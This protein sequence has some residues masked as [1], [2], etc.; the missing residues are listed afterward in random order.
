MARPF[1]KWVGGKTQLLDELEK[2]LPPCSDEG[3]DYVEPFLGG[4]ALFFHLQKNG[5][6]KSA[7]LNDANAELILCYRAVRDAVGLL[8]YELKEI[9]RKIPKDM[10]ARKTQYFDDF[11]KGWNK[12]PCTDPLRM[13]KSEMAKRAALTIYLNKTCFNGLFRVNS[14]GEFNTPFGFP[15]NRKIC[16]GKTLIDAHDALQGV[17]LSNQSCFD[18]KITNGNW[19]F[20]Y[21]DPP[22]RP[23]TSTSFVAYDK[24][25][26]NDTHQKKL[27]DFAVECRD[28]EIDVLLSN[29]DPRNYTDD[30]FNN[31]NDEDNYF[32][33]LFVDFTI[34]RINA[35]RM[36]NSD[37]SNRG[38]VSEILVR[39]YSLDTE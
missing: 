18:L 36:I 25:G 13:D 28:N 23:I 8:I 24:S 10:E 34:D 11:R 14:K 5:K 35:K 16:D 33:E 27:K 30:D 22:Y 37:G 9:E 12:N 4:G 29:S 2:R 21:F 1:L 32:D 3:Y 6:I 39:S 26:F 38:K 7:L 17:T 19:N 15:K 20:I 31:G